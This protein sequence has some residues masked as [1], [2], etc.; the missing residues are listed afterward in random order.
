[1]AKLT[2]ISSRKDTLKN[3]KEPERVGYLDR[4]V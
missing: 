2:K 3:V 4:R 1:M